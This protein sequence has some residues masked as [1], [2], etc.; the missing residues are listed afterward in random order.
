LT[1]SPIN[2]IIEVVIV[3]CLANYPRLC[4][5]RDTL[6][7]L[8]GRELPQEYIAVDLPGIHEFV[9]YILLPL[10]PALPIVGLTSDALIL[11][12]SPLTGFQ[13]VGTVSL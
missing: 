8:C 6:G 3:E 7:S 12:L 10:L 1:F 9:F 5:S 11:I 4:L 2:A 13:E